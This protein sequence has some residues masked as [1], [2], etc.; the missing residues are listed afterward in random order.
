MDHWGDAVFRHHTRIDRVGKRIDCF[1]LNPTAPHERFISESG[2]GVSTRST[3]PVLRFT[4]F[5]L[6][7]GKEASPDVCLSTLWFEPLTVGEAP[8]R[9]RLSLD[10][11]KRFP[12]LPL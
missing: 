3:S 2:K 8:K 5:D 7:N 11:W 12:W 1:Q 10:V 6:R 9:G 4:N